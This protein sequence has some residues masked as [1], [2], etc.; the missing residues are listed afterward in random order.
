MADRN[1]DEPQRSDPEPSSPSEA[2]QSDPNARHTRNVTVTIQYAV[3]NGGRL[4][5]DGNDPSEILS[6]VPFVLN[7]TDVPSTAT[8]ERLEQVVSLASNV[9]ISRLHRRFSRPKGISREAFEKLPVL[10]VEQVTQDCCSI[11][12]DDFVEE[13]ERPKSLLVGNKKRDRCSMGSI[14]DSSEAKRSR[15]HLE[16]L[17]EMESPV[18]ASDPQPAEETLQESARDSVQD[19][20]HESVE[21]ESAAK[22]SNPVTYKHSP[23]KLPCGHVFGRECI[24]QWTQEH[25]S[26]PICRASIVDAQGLN[27]P[28]INEEE[29]NIMDQQ[30]FER[31]RTILYGSSAEPE[32]APH[33]GA[34]RPA[35][36][37]SPT[38]LGSISDAAGSLSN[39]IVLRP[40]R[41]PASNGADS[42]TNTRSGDQH[43]SR[44]TN[45]ERT[46]EMS[47]GFVPSNGL[48]SNGTRSGGISLLPITF[49]NLRRRNSAQSPDAEGTANEEQSPQANS[50]QTSGEVDSDLLN[51]S[52]APSLS[53]NLGPNSG[54][55]RG[56]HPLTTDNSAETNRLMTVLDHIFSITNGNR[57][58]TDPTARSE[59]SPALNV[60]SDVP[61]ASLASNEEHQRA[62]ANIANNNRPEPRRGFN[63]NSFFR[64][65]RNTVNPNQGESALPLGVSTQMFSTGVASHRSEEGVSTV[66]FNGEIPAPPMQSQ[67]HQENHHEFQTT[68]SG[69]ANSDTHISDSERSYPSRTD[70]TDNNPN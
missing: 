11:C 43:V 68:E 14:D 27:S 51:R 55:G 24:R 38:N 45:V 18:N 20:L 42:E 28:P 59:T 66:N 39:F 23:V 61:I 3:L 53:S 52:T 41:A 49:I 67:H 21:A 22:D 31:I 13:L 34:N 32:S 37:T 64:M 30:T 58:R 36:E 16:N 29:E 15:V 40:P 48:V 57:P 47:P 7:F 65:A 17:T 5:T 4:A 35:N 63:F 33:L 50:Q 26:C 6:R 60:S 46:T 62:G 56:T 54:M 1:S 10:N 8:Q 70:Q 2:Q 9:A 69:Q 12:Y 19:S 44:D 25:N